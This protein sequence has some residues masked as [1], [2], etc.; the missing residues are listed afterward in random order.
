MMSKLQQFA[1]L[2]ATHVWIVVHPTKQSQL[3]GNEPSMYDCSGSAHW[4]N[5]CDNGII[6]RRPYAK[7]WAQQKQDD[8]AKTGCS[9][10]VNLKV[11]KVRNY[12]AGKLG[13]AKLL[14]SS[15]T[16]GFEE[17]ADIVV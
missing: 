3:A 1:K 12:Y 15:R 13:E 14:F 16:R 6:V 11:D 4:F 5:K 8:K 10:Q 17:A 2:H 7:S 9:R